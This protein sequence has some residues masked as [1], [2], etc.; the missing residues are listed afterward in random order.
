MCLMCG[1]LTSGKRLELLKYAAQLAMQVDDHEPWFIYALTT[2]R[3]KNIGV[4]LVWFAIARELTN[5]VLFDPKELTQN[6][7]HA[8][9]A[10]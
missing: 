4:N 8:T 7:A 3:G 10:K 2:D 5:D 6:Q 1:P 9:A